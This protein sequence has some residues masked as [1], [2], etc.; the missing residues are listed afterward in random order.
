MNIIFLTT[1][2]GYSGAPK[3]LAW[4]ANQMSRSGH[5]VK[6]LAL[7][8]DQCQQPLDSD[9]EFESLS[10]KRSK[11]RIIR[12]SIDILK[13]LN[14]VHRELKKSSP[15][16]VVTF[17]DTVGYMYLL[18]NRFSKRYKMIASER[19][20]PYTHKGI[21]AKIK[22]KILSYADRIVFQT[23]GA[24]ECFSKNRKIIT[25]SV[26]IPNP[27]I[28]KSIDES[29]KHVKF[30]ERDERIVSVGRLDLKQKRHDVMIDAFERVHQKHPELELHIY[31]DGQDRERIQ[32]IIDSRG[33]GKSVFL[34]GRTDSVERE[35]FNARAF[36]FSSDFEGIPNAL[37]EAMLAGVPAVATDCSPGGA[38]LLIE[39]YENGILVPRGDV[40][41]LSEALIRVVED[42]ERADSFSSKSPLIL[43]RFSESEISDMWRKCFTSLDNN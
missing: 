21:S 37:I 7:Y 41:T 36:L 31:G 14:V 4:I 33:L 13:S 34:R 15:D 26:V 40:A 27:I 3:M 18:K 24:R 17:L 42:E 19:S 20:D 2:L 12:N 43:E 6:V 10:L 9:I 38:R 28:P 29:V 5:S 23:E 8:S 39:N 35:I 11:N 30:C 16:V 22:H 1:V 32:A 25:K